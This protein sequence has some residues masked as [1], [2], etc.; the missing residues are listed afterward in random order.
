MSHCSNKD[1]DHSFPLIDG[2][3][4]RN[5]PNSTVLSVSALNIVCLVLRFPLPFRNHPRPRDEGRLR[6]YPLRRLLLHLH[7]LQRKNLS[8]SPENRIEYISLIF[9]IYYLFTNIFTHHCCRSNL[10]PV[11]IDHSFWRSRP[12]RFDDNSSSALSK[13]TMEIGEE[14]ALNRQVKPWQVDNRDDKWIGKIPDKSVR[15]NSIFTP[16]SW[17]IDFCLRR[18]KKTNR[19]RHPRLSPFCRLSSHTIRDRRLSETR[20][21]TVLHI[22]LYLIKDSQLVPIKRRRQARRANCTFL[23]FSV[24][25]INF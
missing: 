21:D 6:R 23:L 20:L 25:V 7:R 22:K 16:E 5:S 18:S 9:F 12:K 8:F 11:E 17:T 14:I 2:I 10:S 1:D 24:G 19:R 3:R 13:V 4:Q 15:I